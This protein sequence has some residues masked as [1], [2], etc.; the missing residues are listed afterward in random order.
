[1]SKTELDDDLEVTTEYSNDIPVLDNE[2]VPPKKN[3]IVNDGFIQLTPEQIK[4]MNL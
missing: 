4:N 2:V 3:P 1:M